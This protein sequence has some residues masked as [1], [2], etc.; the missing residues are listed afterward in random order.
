MREKSFGAKK[1]TRKKKE[2]KWK[3]QGNFNSFQIQ[4]LNYLLYDR[5]FHRKVSER[6]ALD[7][8][9]RTRDEEESRNREAAIREREKK[10]PKNRDLESK[11]ASADSA[12]WE[13]QLEE[14][15]VAE[16]ERKRR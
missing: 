12:L 4:V 1:K 8:E 6:R 3:K 11:N 7:E 5:F 9:R 14:D 2:L 10:L 16:A 15:A 13:K